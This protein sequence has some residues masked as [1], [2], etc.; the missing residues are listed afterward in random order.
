[1]SENGL[2]RGIAYKMKSRAIL[3]ITLF[4]PVLWG[5]AHCPCEERV[6]TAPDEVASAQPADAYCQAVAQHREDEASFQHE[7]DWTLHRV[8]ALTYKGCVDWRAKHLK[9][10]T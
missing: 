8:Y 10:P 7:D 1:M 5:C 6:E 4:C 3:A 2:E 9:Q